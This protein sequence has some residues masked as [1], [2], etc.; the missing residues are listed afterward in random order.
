MVQKLDNSLGDVVRPVGMVVGWEEWEMT[1]S[2]SG[3]TTLGVDSAKRVK[4]LEKILESVVEDIWRDLDG[5][6]THEQIRQAANEIATQFHDATVTTF[7]PI[8][9]RRRTREK[10]RSQA[11]N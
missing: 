7:V 4:H 11:E 9:I 2:R 5:Q 8:F 3:A 10:L 1:L 6:V